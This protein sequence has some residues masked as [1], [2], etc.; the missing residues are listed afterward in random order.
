[1]LGTELEA[2][3]A[4]GICRKF[5]SCLRRVCVASPAS[6]S[7][8]DVPSLELQVTGVYRHAVRFRHR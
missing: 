2:L 5:L 4:S 6:T 3:A 7:A 1:M 8:A